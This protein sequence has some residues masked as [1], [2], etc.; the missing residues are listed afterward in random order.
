MFLIQ[1]WFRPASRLARQGLRTGCSPKC[2]RKA[3]QAKR[4]GL[5]DERPPDALEELRQVQF[6]CFPSELE[7]LVASCGKQNPILTETAGST[8]R[9]LSFSMFLF[10][11]LVSESRES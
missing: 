3:L 4:V 10:L 7:L 2:E 5:V 11:A 9:V 6:S 8:Q 1:M